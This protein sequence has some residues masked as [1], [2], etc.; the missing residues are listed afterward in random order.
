MPR[1]LIPILLAPKQAIKLLSYKQL[2]WSLCSHTLH[3]KAVRIE[4]QHSNAPQEK[5]LNHVTSSCWCERRIWGYEEACREGTGGCI[6]LSPAL[7]FSTFFHFCRGP[8]K[9]TSIWRSKFIRQLINSQS[10]FLE[11]IRLE[12]PNN[13]EED[14]LGIIIPIFLRLR[15]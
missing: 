15:S 11:I 13:W 7:E 8:C 14:R 5:H 6:A 10:T 9:K 4:S 3:H 1:S 12:F 2:L